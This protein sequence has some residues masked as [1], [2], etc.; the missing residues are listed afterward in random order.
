MSQ[1]PGFAPPPPP[2]P[3]APGERQPTG[4]GPAPTAGGGREGGRTAAFVLLGLVIGL[5]VG[6]LG[7]F[8]AGRMVGDDDTTVR[9]SDADPFAEPGAPSAASSR[10][11]PIALDTPVELGNGWTLEVRSFDAAPRIEDQEPPAGRQ[12]VSIELA[13]TYV[14]GEQEAQ[15]PFF[16][17]DLALLGASGT[18]ST[19]FDGACFAP[20][21]A[22]DNLGDVFKGGTATGNLCIAVP[23]DE[24]D[25]LV[26]VAEPALSFDATKTY[27]TVR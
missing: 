10:D 20:E 19:T 9:I 6:G 26:L 24:V 4:P 5:V 13:A 2:P 11:A 17:M 23:I 15:S 27:F 22:F 18:A 21:P 1:G 3:G 7:G 12:W 8:V 25:D 16:G 14:E